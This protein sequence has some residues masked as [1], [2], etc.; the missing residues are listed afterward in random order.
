MLTPLTPRNTFASDVALGKLLSLRDNVPLFPTKNHFLPQKIEFFIGLWGFPHCDFDLIVRGRELMAGHGLKTELHPAVGE[1]IPVLN[2]LQT[3]TRHQ[4]LS[5]WC[6]Q[7]SLGGFTRIIEL[8]SN[9][10]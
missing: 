7:K 5:A 8:G 4:F 6:N 9:V 1:H 3:M 2:G 10:C